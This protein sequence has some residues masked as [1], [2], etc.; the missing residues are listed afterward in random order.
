VILSGI[1]GYCIS[2]SEKGGDNGKN[3]EMSRDSIENYRPPSVSSPS[4]EN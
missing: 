1:P 2:W 3:W 4:G